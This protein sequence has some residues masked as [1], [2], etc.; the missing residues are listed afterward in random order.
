[1]ISRSRTRRGCS[2]YAC[3]VRLTPCAYEKNDVG[4]SSDRWREDALGLDKSLE[5]GADVGLDGVW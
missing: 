5:D 3:K 4:A 2:V 1:M